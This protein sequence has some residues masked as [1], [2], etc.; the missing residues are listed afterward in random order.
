MVVRGR[1][2]RAWYVAGVVAAFGCISAAGSALTASSRVPRS[3][4][5][6][7]SVLASLSVRDKAAQLVW[8]Q[9]LGDYNSE[10][11]AAWARIEGLIRDQHVG[12]FIMSVGSPFETAVKLNAMQAR[13]AVPL[14]IAADYETGAGFR[15]RGGYFLPNAINLGGAT[16]FAPQMALGATRDT[17]LAYEQGRITALE[18]RALGVQFV[19]APVM[20]VN[21]NPANPV[22]GARSFGEDPELVARMGSSLIR[23]LQEHGTIATAKHFPGHGDTETNSHLEITRVTASR[24]RLD[25]LELVP[26]RRAIATGVGAIMT[27][28]GV[29]PALDTSPVPVTLSPLVMT[30][31]LRKQLGF[32]GLLVT[33]A[34]DM[35]GVLAQVRPTL[36]RTMEPG[37]YGNG[38]VPS[39][40]L[41]EVV[42]QALLAGDD[43]LLMPSDVPAAIDAVVAGV[44][45]GRITESRLDASV[46]RVLGIKQHLGL[47]RLRFVSLDSVSVVVGDS[48]NG[49]AAQRIAQLSIT[50][51][52]DSLQLVPLAHAPRQ[53]VLSITIAIRTD[54]GAGT[55]FNTE[56][57][58]GTSA[59]RTEYVD[60]A[61]PDLSI[62]RLV[63]LAD[64]AD[65]TVISSYLS[66][67]STVVS[68]A[69]PANILGLFQR[70]SE[71]GRHVVVVSFGN[72]YLLREIP[73][74]PAYLLAWGPFPV[75]QRAAAIALIGEEAI[76]GR[77]P[78]S[79]PPFVLFGAGEQRRASVGH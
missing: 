24:A 4:P 60:P 77:M 42:M 67:G 21:N 46:R 12:G 2:A 29:V 32:E 74:V 69:A 3:P 49:A 61:N 34:L 45:S 47:D 52:K 40:G 66:Q 26:F 22:I 59:L 73:E 54:L 48:A 33:D 8:P 57:R 41:A 10:N 38:A 9:V 58:R 70:L 56:L 6:V 25:T 30:D 27:F 62:D 18:A 28:H 36:T 13:S 17:S 65:V 1:T 76:T 16:V 71:G 19:F 79:I 50:L 55:I 43:I 37:A 31:L 72:P 68:T 14:L 51:A 5:W 20:D 35:T 53:R 75:S 7:D 39:A 63:G 64:S 44:R 15:T 78:I 11:S 23:G